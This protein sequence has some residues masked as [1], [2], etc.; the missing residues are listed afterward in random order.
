MGWVVASLLF[1]IAVALGVTCRRLY[2]QLR[3]S[4][5]RLTRLTG[6]L[7]SVQKELIEVKN[8]GKKSFAAS[9]EALIVVERDYTIS[10]ANK[11]ARRLFGKPAKGVT[12][13]TWTRQHRLQEL[14]EQ[15]LQGK[16]LPPLYFDL[17]E[18]SLVAH[19]R[20][21]KENKEVVAVALAIND[22]TELQHLSR[23]RRDFVA[24]IS[25]ELRTPLASIQL[26]TET[27]IN[28]QLKNKTMALKLID[29][30]AT[31]TDVL[32]QLAQELLDLS[33]IE[34]GQAPL[35]MAPYSLKTIVDRQVERLL[36]QARRKGIT[37]Q[38]DIAGEIAVLVDETM[39]G[40]V[41]GNLIHNAIKFT[42]TGSVTISAHKNGETGAEADKDSERAWVTVSVSDTGV[43]IPPDE[44]GRIFERF[45]IVD[46]ARSRRKSGTGLGLAIA[47]HIVEAHGGRIWAKSD[48]R[49]GATF[50]F[51]LL[52]EDKLPVK[53]V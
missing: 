25:H 35:K 27:L 49:S 53:D 9:T 39:I 38:T 19:T 7:A 22:V 23:A 48:G 44:I 2:N 42:D 20:F 30:I 47:K 12:L 41:I 43:G 21:V 4:Q 13:M 15:A 34:S 1:L 24:N 6:E 29:K 52:A 17:N 45:Y 16:K 36:P 32:S 33:M 26:L 5:A 31:Q 50:F 3:Q 51:T 8:R 46:R 11:V 14:V 40:R 28:S 10:S 37:L 18:R